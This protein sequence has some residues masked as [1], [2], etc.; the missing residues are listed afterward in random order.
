MKSKC[1]TIGHLDHYDLWLI[2]VM[3]AIERIDR[4]YRKL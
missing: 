3:N 1:A 2:V 4:K